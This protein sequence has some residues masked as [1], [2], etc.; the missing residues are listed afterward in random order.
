MQDEDKK[1]LKG[2]LLAMAEVGRFWGM[3]MQDAYFKIAI[4][5]CHLFLQTCVAALLSLGP[6]TVF[7]YTACRDR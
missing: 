1:A 4:E 5:S 3:R 7:R 2:E 6:R